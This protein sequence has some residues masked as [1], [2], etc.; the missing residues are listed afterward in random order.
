MTQ[1]GKINAKMPLLLRWLAGGISLLF[2]LYGC[3]ASIMF[4]YRITGD[5]LLGL[6]LRLPFPCFL[7]SFY[8]LWLSVALSWVLFITQ[9][10]VRSFTIK[11]GS[12]LL[13]PLDFLGVIYFCSACILTLAAFYSMR[14]RSKVAW[15]I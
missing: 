9:W 10:M 13:N 14:A 1:S 3:L 7:T 8:S 15:V 12:G 4:D 2:T 5:V 11:P 6:C